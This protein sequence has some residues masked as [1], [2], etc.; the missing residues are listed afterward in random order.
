VENTGATGNTRSSRSDFWA[1]VSLTV[2]AALS[3]STAGLFP[4]MVSTDVFSTLF[5]RSVL[6][7]LS[8][9][10]IYIALN[11]HRAW[12]SLWKF[13]RAEL[14]MSV[15][16]AIAMISFVAAFFFTRI[17]DVV[18]IYSAFPM[19]TLMLS[20]IYLR[21]RIQRLDLL[22]ALIV[23]VGM[24]LILW[25]QTSLHNL[26]GVLLSLTATVMFAL[27]TIGIK[28]HPE[29][30]MIKVT[31]LGAFQSALVV[32]P[33][34]SVVNT[35]LHDMAWLWLFGFLNVGVGFGLYLLG[36]RRIR[37][38]LASLICMIE[39]PLAPLWAFIFLDEAVSPQSLAGGA[40]ILF[41]VLLNMGAPA[42]LKTRP[43]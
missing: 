36:V 29:A 6:G 25:A 43:A 21:T 39:I 10:L 13:S 4:R 16:N 2:L 24:G 1:G 8:V 9:L 20:A 12:S 18:F 40:V 5:W 42:I 41:A 28:K 30:E 22:C 7:G 38:T 34:A 15:F 33:F 14:V 3:W 27:L 23:A 17:A 31:Y 35:S 19:L 11:R 32:L 37:P 26:W